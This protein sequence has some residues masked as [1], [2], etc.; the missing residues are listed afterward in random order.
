MD[1]TLWAQEVRNL[2]FKK[3]ATC[4]HLLR[5]AT[6]SHLQPL[7]AATEA[8]VCQVAA[9]WLPSGCKWLKW[10]QVAASVCKCCCKWLKCQVAASGCKWLQVAASGCQVAWK[11]VAS[12]CLPISAKWLPSGSHLL[13]LAVSAK[14]CKLPSGSL[15]FQVADG[16]SGLQLGGHLATWR[17]SHWLQPLPAIWQWLKTS[18]CQVA[19]S[20][21]KW[22][23]GQV[24]ATCLPSGCQVAA[25]WLQV[26]ARWHTAATWQPLGGHLAATWRP[27]DGHLQPSHL[28]PLATC[29]HCRQPLAATCSHLPLGRQVA[30]ASGCKWL[31]RASVCK[32]LLF[33]KSKWCTFARSLWFQFT[34]NW[35]QFTFNWFQ[36]TFNWFQFTFNW[37]QF[38]FNWF[39]FTF[40]WFLIEIN[41]L[42]IGIN[43]LSI[44]INLLSIDFNL[45]SIEINLLS[46][47]FQMIS[48]DFNLLSIF[49]ST[50]K[51]G[52]HNRVPSTQLYYWVSEPL[53]R[54]HLDKLFGC[55]FFN[56]GSIRHLIIWKTL[57]FKALK[58]IWFSKAQRK[59][60]NAFCFFRVHNR[61]PSTQLYYW[62]SEPLMRYHLEKLFG[63][64]FLNKGL[65][66]LI[67][68]KTLHFKALTW[69]W[70]SKVIGPALLKERWKKH[71]VFFR[72]HNRVPSTQLYYWVSE[73]LMRYHLEKLFGCI[74]F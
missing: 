25:K 70:F 33:W 58:W 17:P 4:S 19:A 50:P 66:H 67:I 28:Q 45:F 47:Y 22:L 36:F 46:V 43:L 21:C 56:K 65:M 31:Q 16:A 6:C 61:V 35:F 54:Y 60:E 51:V 10:L 73:P 20:G 7:A 41:L 53:M 39:Q 42:S 32:W 62:V 57:H 9:K 63:C 59:V 1:F 5:A 13:P 48:I 34:F 23:T 74:F 37:F 30:A 26:A 64:S 15:F 38:T 14:C 12:K 68:W 40:N 49:F 52:V 72:V 69:I 2:I 3:A 44:E 29:S 11:K 18:G 8:S 27:L 55:C 24:A 71:F